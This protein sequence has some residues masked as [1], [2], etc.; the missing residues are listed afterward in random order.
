MSAFQTELSLIKEKFPDC[1]RIIED[2]YKSDS[3]FKSLCADLF[4]CSKL[5]QDFESEI[6]EKR[7]A[8]SEYTEIVHELEL[9]LT[10]VIK[11][12]GTHH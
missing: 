5:I 4:L 11:S 10:M 8:L 6:A 1:K 2:L 7:H 3:D 9:E 12:N